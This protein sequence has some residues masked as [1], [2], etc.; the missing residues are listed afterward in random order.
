MQTS[1]YLIQNF[2]T[3]NWLMLIYSIA[4]HLFFLFLLLLLFTWLFSFIET[5]LSIFNYPFEGYYF[6]GTY[7]FLGTST[8]CLGASTFFGAYYFFC[9]F[10]GASN[11]S[12]SF[13]FGDLFLAFPPFDSYFLL[14]VF[15]TTTGAGTGTGISYSYYST[16]ATT[17]GIY[18]AD[19]F[20]FFLFST[21]V[22]FLPWVGCGCWGAGS[23]FLSFFSGLNSG[24]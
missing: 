15:W 17:W 5:L 18:W 7:D 11:Y 1:L 8:T 23:A 3:L 21:C 19:L 24:Y 4:N 20:F 12:T 13:S 2:L 6:F 16:D 22:S 9:S 10:F 14:V